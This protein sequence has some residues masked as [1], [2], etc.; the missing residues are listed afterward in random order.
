MQMKQIFLLFK[1]AHYYLVIMF[2]QMDPYLLKGH[3]IKML[4]LK[5]NCPPLPAVRPDIKPW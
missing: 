3:Q 4:I 2:L 5:C 1:V